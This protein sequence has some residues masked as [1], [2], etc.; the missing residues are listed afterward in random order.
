MNVQMHVC[1]G[2]GG[3]GQNDTDYR[4][5]RTPVCGAVVLLLKGK[6]L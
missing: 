4:K 6:G 2:A 1:D 3:G 5:Q